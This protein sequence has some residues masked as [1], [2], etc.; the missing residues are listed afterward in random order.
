M[1]WSSAPEA[2]WLR[3]MAYC[4]CARDARSTACERSASASESASADRANAPASAYAYD[5]HSE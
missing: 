3:E 5:S 4:A 2:A 1:A